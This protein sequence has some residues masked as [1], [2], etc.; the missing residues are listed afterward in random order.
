V[1]VAGNGPNVAQRGPRHVGYAEHLAAR[2]ER[3]K[4]TM[5]MEPLHDAVWTER[6]LAG[7]TNELDK[8]A[9]FV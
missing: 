6:L 8:L 5:T 2:G 1:L 3:T 4:V 9:R 7:R